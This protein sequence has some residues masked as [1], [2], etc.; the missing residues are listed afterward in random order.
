[1]NNLVRQ[2]YL[3]KLNE[4]ESRIPVKIRKHPIQKLNDLNKFDDI[5]SE[6]SITISNP[7]P[8]T[9]T[10]YKKDISDIDTIIKQASLEYNIDENLIKSIIKVESNFNPNATSPKGAMGLMQLMPLTAEYLGVKDPYDIKENIFAGTRYLKSLINRYDD[11]SLALASYNAGPGNVDRY[12]GI[13][14]FRETQNYVQKVL[15]YYNSKV[16]D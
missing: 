13:P 8:N 14:P 3:N 4:I 12:K 1:M 9:L 11:L 5:L 2:I 7:T 15:S 6:K 16:F 10:E